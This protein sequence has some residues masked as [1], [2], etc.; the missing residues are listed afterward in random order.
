MVHLQSL[1]RGNLILLGLGVL[2]VLS[3]GLIRPQT[4]IVRGFGGFLPSLFMGS[5][6]MSANIS[7]L[8]R[9]LRRLMRPD[10]SKG[11]RALLTLLLGFKTIL[12]GVAVFL[13]FHY[14]GVQPL[15]F[16]VGVVLVLLLP[17]VLVGWRLL[18]AK[19]L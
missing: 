14:V 2:A 7:L 9:M 5:L 15:A 8:A 18:R 6:L 1:E 16:V 12:L 3:E 13:L 4:V 17:L 10:A 11:V 19:P